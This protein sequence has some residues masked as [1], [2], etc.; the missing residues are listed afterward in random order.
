[1]RVVSI[2]I[3]RER[4]VKTRTFWHLRPAKIQIRLRIRAVWSESSLG[5]FWIAKD[6]KFL[7]AYNEDSDQTARMHRLI[8]SL[9]Y[10]HMSESTFSLVVAQMFFIHLLTTLFVW[11]TLKTSRPR[12]LSWMRVRLEIRKLRV[13]P[14]T[15]S[16]TFFR[17]DWSWE[18]SCGHFLPSAES[19]RAVV[20]FWRKNVHNTG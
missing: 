18:T 8:L 14:P 5:A 12:W 7:L 16:A 15:W 19:R 20:S 9:C 2:M 3:K 1:M 4:N 11:V 13:R 6:A 10:A 17:G